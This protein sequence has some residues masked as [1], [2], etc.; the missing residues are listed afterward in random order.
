M[1]NHGRIQK[2]QKIQK[3]RNVKFRREANLAP[4]QQ[5]GKSPSNDSKLKKGLK[6]KKRRGRGP[7]V[8]PL[9]PPTDIEWYFVFL[10]VT[11]G[12]DAGLSFEGDLSFP[13]DLGI[14]SENCFQNGGELS[15]QQP[16]VGQLAFPNRLA[17]QL[18]QL[19]ASRTNRGGVVLA[20]AGL[21][22]QTL[23]P[24]QQ[25]VHSSLTALN[26]VRKS[27]HLIIDVKFM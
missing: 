8:P 27:V 7:L 16:E 6:S 13:T 9:N 11:L 25:V 1:Y 12:C 3:E 22:L 18:V 5:H 21:P 4:Y 14:S 26:N 10:A 2:I 24:T 15:F 20:P 19:S 17:R 23:G